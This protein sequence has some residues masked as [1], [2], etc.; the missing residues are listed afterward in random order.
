MD[1]NFEKSKSHILSPLL[2]YYYYDIYDKLQASNC[3]PPVQYIKVS[4]Y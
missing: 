1:Y 3:L 2:Q 4:S